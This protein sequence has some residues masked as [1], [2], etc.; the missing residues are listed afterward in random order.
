MKKILI[1]DDDLEVNEMLVQFLRGSGY[2]AQGVS[3]GRLVSAALDASPFDL[4]ISDLIMPEQEG[5]ET[6]MNLRNSGSKIPIIA[7]SGGGRFRPEASLH[8]AQMLG[9]NCALAK[10][11]ALSSLL[12]SVKDCLKEQKKAPQ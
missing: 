8:M 4:I 1:V 7:I 9:A 10:P 5:I 11:V 3:D 2:D 12:E 6:I